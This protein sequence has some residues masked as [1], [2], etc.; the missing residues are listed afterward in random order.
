MVTSNGP[1]PTLPAN[2]ASEYIQL[3]AWNVAA[4]SYGKADKGQGRAARKLENALTALSML[5]PEERLGYLL[6][7]QLAV[8]ELAGQPASR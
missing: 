6:R 1:Q 4:S 8:E 7:A 2:Q 5:S 3:R